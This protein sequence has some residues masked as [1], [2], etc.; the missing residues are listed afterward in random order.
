LSD[1]QADNARPRIIM[2][3]DNMTNL[4]MGRN[5]LKAFYE[6]YPAPSAVKFFEILE[7]IHPDLILLDIEMPET[8]GYE[9]L[10]KMRQDSRFTDI[11]VIFLTARTDENSELKGFDLGAADYVSK[12]FSGPLLLKRIENQLLIIRQKKELDEFRKA[13]L[14][15]H[16]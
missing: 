2:V 4:T 12:P 16:S 10:K 5:M 6:V 11:P 14:E 13:A 3:D 8:N 9:V 15:Q 7:H 1:K